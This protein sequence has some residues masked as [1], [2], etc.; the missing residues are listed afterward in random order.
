[1][2]AETID[3]NKIINIFRRRYLIIILAVIASLVTSVIYLAFL[4]TKTYEADVLLY[5]WQ[6]DSDSE[7][8]QYTD[9]ML[10]SQLVNDYQV[11]IKSRLVINEV[12]DE[13]N[14]SRD[15]ASG[16]AN[17]ITVKTKNNTRNITITVIDTEPQ[18][19][20]D[21]A[22]TVAAVFSRVVVDKMGAGSVNII[23][24]AVAPARY[25]SPNEKMILA[26]ALILGL[27][28]GVLIA[29]LVEMLDHRVRSSAEVEAITGYRSLG[30]VPYFVPSRTY[31][32]DRYES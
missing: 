7:S 30:V 17:R 9:L 32:E 1:M 29:V 24:D 20:A 13:L 26:T 25:S 6:K 11:L 10:F 8:S 4:T 28:L 19:A 21:I 23:D 12:Y 5:I 27:L 18:R 2:D 31:R 14:L 16:L 15:Q 22:N 3:L